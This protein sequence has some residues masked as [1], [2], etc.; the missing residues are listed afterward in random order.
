MKHVWGA[1][2]TDAGEYRTKNQD[3]I[4][5]CCH[6]KRGALL[7]VA[8]ICDG[9]GSMEQ[10]EMAS[11][12]VT[13]GIVKWFEHIK[14][15]Y[16]E[17]D[18]AAVVADLKETI[19]E[20][21]ELVVELR[22]RNGV[23]IGCTMSLILLIGEDYYIFHV[24]DSRI[25]SIDKD[26]YQL[27]YDEVNVKYVDGKEKK[28]LANYIGRDMELWLNTGS[29]KNKENGGYVIGSDGLFHQL[30]QGDIE[31]IRNGMKS[32]KG[33]QHACRKLIKEMRERGERDNISCALLK[34]F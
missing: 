26:F 17:W 10:S 15:I 31:L 22:R 2:C 5:C 34:I 14:G 7:A 24:G 19:M 25:A 4:V 23:A 21:N 12:L 3:R 30:V 29:G 32:K 27:T 18:V 1:C 9:I 16:R 6:E 28:Y 33:M 11:E 20:L 8:C 13:D